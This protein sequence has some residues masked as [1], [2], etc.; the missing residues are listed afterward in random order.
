[1]YHESL[2]PIIIDLYEEFTPL[3]KTIAD[4]FIANKTREDF[5]IKNMKDKL[6]VSEASL[7]RF[8]QKCGFRGYRE[9]SFAYEREFIEIIDN[10][11]GSKG[12]VLQTY[13]QIL[14]N[15]SSM[16]DENQIDRLSNLITNA[17]KVQAIGIGS[18]GYSALEMKS[19]FARLGVLIDAIDKDDD[20]KM[21]SVFQDKDSLLIGISISG[22]KN[23]ILFSL[24]KAHDNG[25]KTVLITSNKEEDYGYVD[26][27]I[28]VPE[29]KKFDG[30]GII[31][32]QIP[33]LIVIDVLYNH[34]LD[35]D[36]YKSKRR[37]FHKKTLEVLSEKK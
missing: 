5:S 33:V 31:S 13:S 10:G 20:M 9:F 19:R 2:L 12:T 14:T 15:I 3:E 22:T 30:S 37:D 23:S 25:A 29:M 27:I 34:F 32:P 7:T 4:Y 36:K 1:M 21:L 8:A 35:S 18:S 16:I 17:K 11:Y 6:Y 28:L 24:K 26:E